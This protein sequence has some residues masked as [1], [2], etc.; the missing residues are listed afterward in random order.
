MCKDNLTNLDPQ[1]DAA[2][3]QPVIEAFPERWAWPPAWDLSDYRVFTSALY[4]EL[5]D[6]LDEGEA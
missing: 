6:W 3:E 1:P 2:D 4:D 5:S